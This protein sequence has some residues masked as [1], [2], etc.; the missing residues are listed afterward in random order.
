VTVDPRWIRGPADELAIAEGCTFDEA[1]GR[2]VCDFIER[3]C[4][5][6]KGRW[7]G[8]PLVLLDWQRDFL[9]RLFGWKRADGFRR[10]QTAYL[11]V[12]KKNGK[13]TLVSALCLFLLLADG[14]GAPEVFINAYD[15]E[16]AS[17]VYEEAARMVRSSPELSSRLDV[18]DSKKRIVDPAG[19]GKVVANSADV[20]SKD[21][22]NASGV[23]FDELH[24]QRTR[25]LWDIF[26]YAGESRDQPLKVSITTAGEDTEGVWHEQRDHSEKVN[27][28]ISP[29]TTHLGVVYR[30]LETDDIDDPETW[31]KANPSLGVTISE[32]RFRQK[33][34]EAKGNPAKFALFRRLR[35]NIITREAAKY[36][37][38]KTWAE[39][40]AECD[41]GRLA[42]V[43]CYGG[44]D[45]SKT[46]DLTALALIFGD[47]ESGFDV[48]MRF[49]L[50]EEN[51]VDLEHRHGMPYR[52]WAD[53]GL[54]TLT[55]GN[56]VDYGFV[57]KEIVAAAG[58][59]SPTNLLA[60]P[61]NATKL[62]TELKEQDGL[63][64]E[65]IRQGFLSLSPATKELDR[66][67]SGRKLRHGGHPILKWHAS[68]AVVRTDEN[69][70]VMLSKKKSRKP[71]DGLAALVNAIAAS[72]AG[73][74]QRR[75]V[76]EDE[77]LMFV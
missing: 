36:I 9:M 4:R 11:E 33:L 72:M 68:N 71:I 47:F 70:N 28:G 49:W 38:V 7:R 76:Y 39:C 24:R 12:A 18:I 59:F 62:L 77:G 5:Q 63:H 44:L 31:R 2:F 56:V 20:P 27:A 16:Q 69:D 32:D 6:S 21:G 19:N 65:P 52:A 57:R 30:A 22:P 61:Y 29:D 10:F 67:I 51:I 54:I 66:M 64:V 48:L 15:R 25:D 50:P 35:L 34:A 13:S 41:E 60:D 53:Q 58:T 40:S 74:G 55:D 45:L 46:T 73:G 14:E 17:I 43:P 42:G 26:E 1:A 37:D 75:S 3:F 8:K 23:I